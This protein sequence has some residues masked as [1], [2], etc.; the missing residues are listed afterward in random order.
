MLAVMLLAEDGPAVAIGL[1][2]QLLA[3]LRC[4]LAISLGGL[5][6]RL[7]LV[8]AFFHPRGF[9]FRQLTRCNTLLNAFFLVGLPLVQTVLPQGLWR[10]AKFERK[11]YR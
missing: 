5:F 4:D 8:F 7:Q 2:V 9:F 6:V 10:F 11:Q 3:L 1:V